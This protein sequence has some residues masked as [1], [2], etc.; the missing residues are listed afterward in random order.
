MQ[1]F[2]GHIIILD[3]PY[4]VR[5]MDE[6][7]APYVA[8]ISMIDGFSRTLKSRRSGLS[9]AEGCLSQRSCEPSLQTPH[10]AKP[11]MANAVGYWHYGTNGIR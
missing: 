5:G 4:S 7:L 8:Q 10:R 9:E 2:E 11:D 1:I 3:E 6:I